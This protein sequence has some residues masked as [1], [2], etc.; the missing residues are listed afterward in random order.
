M[1]KILLWVVP[2]LIYI[3]TNNETMDHDDVHTF[4]DRL[5]VTQNVQKKG[6]RMLNF[7]IKK[8]CTFSWI[9]WSHNYYFEVMALKVNA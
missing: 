6:F 1:Q 5:I 2:I 8:D 4:G 7:I 9:I 3:F